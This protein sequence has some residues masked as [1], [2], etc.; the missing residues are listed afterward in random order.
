MKNKLPKELDVETTF[1]T[2]FNQ[3][4]VHLTEAETIFHNPKLDLH[5]KQTSI[6]HLSARACGICDAIRVL[7]YE[8]RN[9]DDSLSI[10]EPMNKFFFLE[11]SIDIE[12]RKQTN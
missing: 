1:N 11:Q 7:G 3:I 2:L 5:Q 10:Q 9:A 6:H 12:V 4:Y 8:I